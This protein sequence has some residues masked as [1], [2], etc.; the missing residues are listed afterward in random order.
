MR[1][2]TRWLVLVL[3]LCTGLGHAQVRKPVAGTDYLP[4]PQVAASEAPA[5][6]FEVVEFFRYDCPHCNSFEPV[7]DPWSKK[8]PKDVVVRRVPVAFDNSQIPMQ[9]L[10]YALEGLQKLEELHGKAFRAIHAERVPLRTPEQMIAW[11]EKQGVDR[12]RFTEMFNS[13]GVSTKAHKATQLAMAYKVSGVPA[14]GVAGRFYTDGELAGDNGK[15]LFV[16]EYLLAELRK[17]R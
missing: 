15:A 13:F 17:G 9:R 10:F 14:L 1:H 12:A 8:L 7:F 5:G 4:L 11:V 2:W 3:G 6:K 16:V